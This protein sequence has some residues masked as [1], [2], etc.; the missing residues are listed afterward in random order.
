M[1]VR[2][3]RGDLVESVHDVAACVADPAG[4]VTFA[5]GDVDRPVFL[6]SAA[7]PFIAAAIVASGAADA[8]GL[9]DR[10]LAVISASHNG[11]PGHVAAVRSILAKAG[12]AESALLCGAHEP[13]YEPA[14]RALAAAGEPPSAVHNNCSGKHA[15]ILALCVRAG[16]DPAGYLA[17][18]HPAQLAILDLCA[19]LSDTTVEHMPLAVDG[20]GIPVYA[21]SL[22]R[23]ATSFARFATLDG[24][25]DADARALERVLRAVRAEPWY[26]AG[27]GRFDTA[28]IEATG[29]RIVGKAGAEGVH[30]DALPREG[31][32]L[33]VKVADGARRATAPAVLAICGRLGAL[34]AG[35]SERLAEFGA[36]EIFNVAGLAVGRLEAAV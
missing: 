30:G 6:R 16:F 2:V 21:V 29:G 32:G 13:S 1:I 24:V 14:A 36:P 15:G 25:A 28:L 4:T 27:T 17:P 18:D 33:I 23:A 8:F 20:C 35:E 9:D 26:L 12:L 22:R 5:A 3:T 11:E 10:E 34:D 7:K 31:L 19:R